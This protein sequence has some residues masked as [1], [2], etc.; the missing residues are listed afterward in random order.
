[1]NYMQKRSKIFVVM[2]RTKRKKNIHVIC[3]SLIRPVLPNQSSI[4]LVC[5]LPISPI[6]WSGRSK[7]TEI[8]ENINRVY[9]FILPTM[10]IR[11]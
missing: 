4:Y 11:P 1:M 10:F 7:P 6:F 2:E 9:A 5:I 3:A 8:L